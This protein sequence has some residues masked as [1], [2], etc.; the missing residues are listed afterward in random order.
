MF[1]ALICLGLAAGVLGPASPAYA[2]KTVY[3]CMDAGRIVYAD[4]PCPAGTGRAIVV[5]DSKSVVT[6]KEANDVTL[7]NAAASSAAPK[8]TTALKS[9]FSSKPKTKA[10]KPRAQRAGKPAS[11]A[12]TR[13]TAEQ[14]SAS[15]ASMKKV[16]TLMD[17]ASATVRAK[18]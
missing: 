1:R 18:P 6:R 13:S 9:K 10:N 2:V 14:A 16:E 12:V 7:R 15:E 8:T 17:A 3:R 11:K 5:D 4:E